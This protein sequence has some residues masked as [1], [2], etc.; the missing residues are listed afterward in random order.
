MIA[1]SEASYIRM[2]RLAGLTLGT[3]WVMLAVLAVTI[4]YPWNP[5][6]T[7][8]VRVVGTPVVGQAMTVEVNY[9]KVRDWVPAEVR[10]SLLNE[11]TVMLPNSPASLPVGCHVTNVVVPLPRH[12]VPTK[13]RLQL[14]TIYRPWPWVEI[15]Y[16]RQSPVFT[17]AAAPETPMK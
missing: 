6:T 15:P 9:C 14:E 12:I 5:I 4:W 8:N 16:V 1:S 13:Y 2:I 17:M 7:V 10:F 11:V 3:V